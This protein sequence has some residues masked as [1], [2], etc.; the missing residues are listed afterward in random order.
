MNSKRI[1]VLTGASS[2]LGLDAARALAL[3]EPANHLIA[4]V[5]DPKNADAL[6]EAV[7]YSQLELIELDVSSLASVSAF[8][9]QV[10]ERIGPSIISGLALNAGIQI[11][12]GTR[13]SA[14]DY[15]L[16]FATNVLGHVVL[17]EKLESALDTDSVV[18]S[19]A[20]GT[21]DPV[22]PLAK[23]YGFK[24]GSFP[25]ANA[26]A[27]GAVSEASNAAQIGRDRY[28]TSKLC[29]ILFTYGM[30]RRHGSDGPRFIA[31]DPGLMPGTGLARS[32]PAIVQ[33]A[34][35]RILPFAVRLM[36]GASTASASGNRM[37]RLLAGDEHTSGTG[38]HIEYTGNA[39]AS[40]ELSYD[41][42]AQDE[43]LA[44]C[45]G[46][47]RTMKTEN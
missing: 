43:L 30:A 45:E 39:I 6:C 31:Y 14:D 2:G 11:T 33:F 23:R 42:Q 17:F 28:S 21:H 26:V 34:W 10:K 29:N 15:E 8:A 24:G 25:S 19:T 47:V 16:T 40:S 20:S 37:A 46:L 9:D 13:T 22:H 36:E 5:R 7:P 35:K 38:L 27:D 32:Q 1:F 3:A 12:N 44:F 18:L 41:E 4:G